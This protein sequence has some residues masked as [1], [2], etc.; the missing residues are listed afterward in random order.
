MTDYRS[1]MTKIAAM[2]RV[3]LT[4]CHLQFVISHPEALFGTADRSH[5][6]A[7]SAPAEEL[8]GAIGF[9]A[10]DTDSG[11]HLNHLEDLARGWIDS[12]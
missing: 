4:I 9:E 5:L 6:A 7:A 11:G 2:E 10:G 1:Q 12:A 3:G 8:V